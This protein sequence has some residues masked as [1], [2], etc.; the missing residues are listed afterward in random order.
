MKTK[1]SKNFIFFVI[2]AFVLLLLYA[3]IGIIG[4]VVD[5]EPSLIY[6]FDSNTKSYTVVGCNKGTGE[7]IVVPQSYR[8][9]PVVAIGDYAFHKEEIAS[10][11][12][13]S[14]IKHIGE[15]AFAECKSLKAVYGMENC[16]E[17]VQISNYTFYICHSLENIKLSPNLVY[18]GEQAFVDCLSLE[19]IELPLSV[20]TIDFGAFAGCKSLSKIIL[21]ENIVKIY[22]SFGLC[23]SLQDIT[24]PASVKELHSIS[25]AGCSKMENIYIDDDN[26]EFTSINGVVYS[27]SKDVL[28]IYPSGRK[29]EYFELPNEVTVIAS[30]SIAHNEHLVSI[31]IPKSVTLIATESFLNSTNLTDINYAGIVEEWLNIEKESDWNKG[32]S[33][34]TIYCTDGQIAKD[35][36]ITY[37]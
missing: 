32:L 1:K 13:P 27:K 17:L 34:F 29:D 15:G 31:Y 18:I 8:N 25:F 24:I 9:Y 28:W 11:T 6:E 30:Q 21:T 5:K 26:T 36:T 37:K 3:I 10:I 2:L 20:K 12:L 7:D 14:T 19:N 35:G 4:N 23:S 22:A 16:E 33:D